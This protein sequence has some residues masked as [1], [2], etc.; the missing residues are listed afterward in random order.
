MLLHPS[1]NTKRR[2][3]RELCKRFFFCLHFF[4][5]SFLGALRRDFPPHSVMDDAF[6]EAD[7]HMRAAQLRLEAAAAAAAA[8]DTPWDG[9][10]RGEDWVGFCTQ[11]TLTQLTPTFPPTHQ[12]TAA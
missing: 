3:T 5:T 1:N 12:A 8:H 6:A 9:E 4:F 2:Q 11:P 10:E 7:A